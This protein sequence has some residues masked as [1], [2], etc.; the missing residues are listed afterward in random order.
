[1]TISVAHSLNTAN[2]AT[3]STLALAFSVSLTA[4]DTIHAAAGSDTSG[5]ATV[6]SFSD[7]TNTYGSVLDAQNDVTHAQSLAHCVAQN[8][9]AG[10]PTVTVNFSVSAVNR[11]LWIK[12]ITGCA[13]AS[14]DGHSGNKQ[15]SPGTGTDAIT[16]GTATNTK[17]PAL[18]SA[19]CT[20]SLNQNA[21]A[22]AGTGF[23]SEGA[24]WNNQYG[25]GATNTAIAENKRITT[26]SA[27]AA[28]FTAPGSD[29]Y[30][31]VEAIF[32]E[33][34]AGGGAQPT[35]YFLGSDNYF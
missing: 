20:D 10:T 33:S 21:V 24:G 19:F 7:G 17:H 11:G 14:L 12:N 1:M 18:I 5:G 25:A 16:S 4:G 6:S 31:A 15:A 28:T 27:V 32:D 22:A 23:T 9:A 2:S 35:S 29:P 30:M 8:C 13:T 34:G 26:T 3:G